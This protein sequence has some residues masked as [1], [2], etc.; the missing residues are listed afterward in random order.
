MV[1]SEPP[2]QHHPHSI[3]SPPPRGQL[4]SLPIPNAHQRSLHMAQNVMSSAD[5]TTRRVSSLPLSQERKPFACVATNTRCCD[6]STSCCRALRTRSGPP[7]RGVRRR[8]GDSLGSNRLTAS[9][10]YGPI[11]GRITWARRARDSGLARDGA[12]DIC[13]DGWRRQD[14][15][16]GILD[17]R[18]FSFA[19]RMRFSSTPM[20]DSCS[21]E[22]LR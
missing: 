22:V 5:L 17:I 3:S 14:G 13:G 15:R 16:H 19:W 1:S 8:V 7:T 20:F 9:R 12:R 10:A 6:P 21:W 11:G 18:A 2:Y 4:L